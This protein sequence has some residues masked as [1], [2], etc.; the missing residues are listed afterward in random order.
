MLRVSIAAVL[1]LAA[2]APQPDSDPC[3]DLCTS[4]LVEWEEGYGP[5]YASAYPGVTGEAH[6]VLGQQDQ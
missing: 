1:L 6:P 4:T 2:C 3:R 5:D